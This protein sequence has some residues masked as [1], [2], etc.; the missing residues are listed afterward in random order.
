[1]DFAMSK[2]FDGNCWQVQLTGE[3][4]IFSS[5]ELRTQMIQLMG[6]SQADIAIDCK[7]L[8]YIDSTGL[9]ALVGV[10]K[11]SKSLGKGVKLYNVKP[12]IMKLLSIT[13][14]DEAFVVKGGESGE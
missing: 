4:D 12:N 9:G 2:K 6:E 5:E 11:H 7:D 1:M 3:V 10:L 8:M 14:L 13:K